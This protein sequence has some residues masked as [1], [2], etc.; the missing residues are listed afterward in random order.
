VAEKRC[1]DDARRWRKL[2]A[3]R[4]L[5]WRG[6]L[7]SGVERCGGGWGQCSPFIGGL[8]GTRKRFPEW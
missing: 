2:Q 6:E 7:E 3:A 1:D 4:V 8:G 5:E